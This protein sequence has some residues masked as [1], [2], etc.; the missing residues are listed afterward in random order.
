MKN[1]CYHAKLLPKRFH[2]NGHTIGFHPNSKFRTALQR[3][4]K[5]LVDCAERLRY[6]FLLVVL[7]HTNENE[8]KQLHLDWLEISPNRNNLIKCTC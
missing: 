2:L 6:V 3:V 8:R 7:F 1:K 5:Y 4:K